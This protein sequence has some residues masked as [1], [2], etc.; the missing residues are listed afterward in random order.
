MDTSVD[1][2]LAN[3]GDSTSI[4]RK[5]I[6][7]EL[8]HSSIG[9]HYSRCWMDFASNIVVTKAPDFVELVILAV[10]ASDEV[11]IFG[12][13]DTIIRRPADG[14]HWSALYHVFGEA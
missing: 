5:V 7:S 9:N 12:T 10:N 6:G 1:I 4:F 14:S 11:K 2:R 3:D 13:P 8:S